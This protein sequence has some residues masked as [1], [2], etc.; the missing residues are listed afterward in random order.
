MS[1]L[2]E[3]PARI[4]PYTIQYELGRGG[5]GVVYRAVRD[6]GPEVALKIPSQDLAHLFG[7][8]RRE[9]HAL[10]RLRHPGVVRILD[11][12][13]EHGVPWYAMELLH[14]LPLDGVLQLRAGEQ[15]KTAATFEMRGGARVRVAAARAVVR[16]DLPRALTLMYRLARVLAYVHAHGLVHRDLKP[17]NVFVRKGDRPVLVDF[18]LAA[19]FQALMSREVLE[20]GGRPTGTPTYTAPEQARGE[21]VDARADLYSFGVMLYEIVTGRPP[22]DGNTIADVFRMHMYDAPVAPSTL[23]RG[24]PPKLEELILALLEKKPSARLGYAEDVANLLLEAGATPDDE[25]GSAVQPYLYRPDIVGRGETI[26][27]ANALIARTLRGEGAFV[28]LGGVSGI[29]KTSVATV[30]ARE[31]TMMNVRVIAGESAPVGGGPLHPLRP[32]LREIADHCRGNAEALTRILGPRLIVL[33]D[34]DPSLAALD[35]KLQP[36]APEIASRRLFSDL[37]ETLAA[38]AQERPLLLI[39]DDLQWADEVTLRFLSSLGPDYFAGLPLVILGTYR[40]DEAG[41]ELRTLIGSAHV[42]NLPLSRL[43]DESVGAIVRS[44]LAAPDSPASF[45][46]FLAK[47]TEGNPFF[48]G[49]YLRSAVAERLLF[50]EHGRWHLT[51]SDDSYSSV[52]LP[53]TVRDLVGRRLG[54]LS[55]L[56][57]RAAEAASVL[58]RE[59]SEEQFRSVCGESESD[60]LD[61]IAELMEQ[62]IFESAGERIRFAHDKL[63]E[64]AYAG[65]DETR[66]KQLHRR[67]A[68]SIE[69]ACTSDEELRRHESELARHCDAAGMTEKAIGWYARAAETAVGTGACRE[70]IELM[71]RAIAL[72]EASA[73]DSKERHERHAHWQR[74]LSFARFGLGDLPASD[75]HARKSLGELGIA[76]PRTARGWRLR[77]AGEALRQGVHLVLPKKLVQSR[78]SQPV[79]RDVAMAAQKFSEGRYY[80]DDKASM[81]ASGLLAVNSAERLADKA[82]LIHTYANFG[83]VSSALGLNRIATRYYGKARTLAQATNDLNGLGHI[84]YTSAVLYITT[85]DWKSCARYFD[86]AVAAAMQ[87]GDHQLIEMNLIARGFFELYRGRISTAA[88]TFDSVRERARKRLNR[89]HEAW[90]H[91][92]RAASL[93]LMNRSGEALDG[94]RAALELIAPLSDNAKLSSYALRCQA[95]LHMGHLEEAVEAADVTA[96]AVAKIP[97][98]I[99]E[100]YRGLSAPAEVYLE[101]WERGVGDATIVDRMR[102]ASDVLLR[103]LEAVSRRMPLASPVALRL[104][105]VREC[106]DGNSSRGAQ[107]LRKSIATATRLGLPI[108]EGISAYE[109]ARW[110]AYGPER[111]AQLSHARAIL[112]KAGCELYVGRLDKEGA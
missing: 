82:G 37:A 69:R 33:R 42:H 62:Y 52:A 88:A 59:W 97:A 92:W 9:I 1:V 38:F 40:A 93:I 108:E 61:A 60:A 98:I 54:R 96:A 87:T 48:V 74:V 15:E 45:L 34:L 44:M 58:G 25:Q 107:L 49:E 70:A 27:A 16:D 105:G 39:L 94:L 8:L 80:S 89:Q 99:W 46:Q 110:C 64:A 71:N 68:E 101:A 41:P 19:Q 95:L 13:I 77:L 91:T 20:I 22:F 83:A 17:E 90:G 84:G 112:E 6:D 111:R 50:R 23:V 43:D 109:F 29:G 65:L 28:M 57:R 31:A 7:W 86:D 47:Q 10:G 26:E 12:G 32:L 35:E 21:L 102:R 36:I 2:P 79:L 56:A 55:P 78:A 103:R 104:M 81:L 72:D 63:R 18:G 106:L 24:V 100:K 4:G 5:M 53:G 67:A 11:E 14:G 51:A 85:C 30:V 66:R 76:L 75:E 73:V 3:M